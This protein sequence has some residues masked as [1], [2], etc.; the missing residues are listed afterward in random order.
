MH[1]KW[2]VPI[3]KGTSKKKSKTYAKKN[4]VT[5][6]TKPRKPANRGGHRLRLPDY[7]G[8][9]IVTPPSCILDYAQCLLDPFTGPL[10]CIPRWP[11][12][13]SLKV[14]QFLRSN[15]TV[16]TANVGFIAINQNPA[17]DNTGTDAAIFATSG[18]FT[19]ST[20]QTSGTGVAQL[21][22]NGAFAIADFGSTL[23]DIAWRCVSSG[24]RIRFSGAEHSKG[25]TVYMLEQPEHS[26]VI[27][28][29]VAGMRSYDQ[30]SALPCTREWQ[31]LLYQPHRQNDVEYKADVNGL[32]HYMG[33]MVFGGAAA[34]DIP[35]AVYEFEVCNVYEFIGSA[36]RGKTRN[37]TNTT[38]ADGV[39]GILSDIPSGK[40]NQLL[41]TGSNKAAKYV[42]NLAADT[43]LAGLTSYASG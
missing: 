33:I 37:S 32:G 8:S 12:P 26:T 38:L 21:N 3:K 23:G 19:G 42:L 11:S 24:I 22:T 14:R 13:P 4:A 28:L 43:L 6:V 34:G 2:K 9:E 5:P 27:G 29:T 31:T 10:A 16:G 7:P 15:M 30:S 40:M 20:F 1:S 17:N 39:V 41:A 18:S 25:G 35:A 36:A